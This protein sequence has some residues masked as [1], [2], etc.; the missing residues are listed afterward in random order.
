MLGKR[1]EGMK[2]AMHSLAVSRVHIATSNLGISQ[3]MFEMSIA[4]ARDR[5]TSGKPI[6]KRQAIRVKLA[7]MQMMIHA[8][9]CCIIDF[10]DD[11]DL[12]PEGEGHFSERCNLQALLSSTPFVSFPTRCLRSSVATVTSRTPLMVAP[13]FFTATAALCGSRKALLPYSASPSLRV[14][15]ITTVPSSIRPGSLALSSTS[16][17]S[18]SQT[19]IFSWLDSREG[20]KRKLPPFLFLLLIIC[21]ASIFHCL[22]F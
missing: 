22:A 13:S 15:K 2:V 6:I 21:F 14:L 4:R 5:V 12:D 19:K 18:D 7:N 1:G 9:R 10:C 11:F 3:R 8:L 17:S 16:S 20:R